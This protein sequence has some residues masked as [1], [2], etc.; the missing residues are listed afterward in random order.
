MQHMRDFGRVK[1]TLHL[2]PG[3][4]RNWDRPCVTWR[5]TV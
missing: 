2:I 1:Q 5:D 3:K 4:K